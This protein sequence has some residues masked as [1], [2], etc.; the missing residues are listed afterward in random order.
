LSL[1][2]ALGTRFSG[3]GDTIG[4]AYN[5]DHTVHGIGLGERSANSSNM[6]GPC[7]TA[8]IDLR[9]HQSMMR[10]DGAIPGAVSELLAPLLAATARLVGSNPP[11]AEWAKIKAKLR[12]KESELFGPYRGATD[13]TLF[14][15]LIAHDDS[16]GRCF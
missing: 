10:A 3:N 5:T 14:F 16:M 12:E 2:D 8:V 6:V 15:L 4:F 7:S 9:A 11:R 1:S 13:Q